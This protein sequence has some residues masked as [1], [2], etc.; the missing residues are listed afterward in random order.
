MNFFKNIFLYFTNIK[1]HVWA[2]CNNRIVQIESTS[3]FWGLYVYPIVI[4]FYI[5]EN[6]KDI[7]LHFTTRYDFI[8]NM[9]VVS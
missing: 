2:D 8:K 5:D 6:D 7:N 3:W 9:H 4:Y 1:N